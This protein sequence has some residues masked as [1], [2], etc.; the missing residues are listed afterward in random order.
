MAVFDNGTVCS[1]SGTKN[2]FYRFDGLSILAIKSITLSQ[3]NQTLL[4]QMEYSLSIFFLE[5]QT[6]ET[7]VIHPNP[8]FV[9]MF[10][11]S[12][13]SIAYFCG[14]SLQS[15]PASA[16]RTIPLMVVMYL[17]DVYVIPGSVLCL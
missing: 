4:G 7:R 15:S 6:L 11:M 16:Q 9:M 5:S 13:R 3:S 1:H 10:Q 12:V 8:Q 14:Q 17:G 2:T